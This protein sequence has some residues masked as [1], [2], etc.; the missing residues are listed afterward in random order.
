MGMRSCATSSP[1]ARPCSA[2][3]GFFDADHYPKEN[4]R[5][6]MHIHVTHAIIARYKAV[7]FVW[8]HVGLC[9][10]LSTLHPAV[11]A[12][13]IEVFFER[14]AT[15]LWLDTSW[16]VLA[17]QVHGRVLCALCSVH[18]PCAPCMRHAHPPSHVYVCTRARRSHHAELRQL[19][20]Q[21]H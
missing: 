17:K 18:V 1:G 4:F 11:H 21:A 8:A 14:H 10:E 6:I 2:R 12:R 20:R 19:R 9:M 3:S 15:N 7:K 13:I 16:D 5:K